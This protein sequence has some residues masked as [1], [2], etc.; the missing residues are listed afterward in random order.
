MFPIETPNR[1]CILENLGSHAWLSDR[2]ALSILSSYSEIRHEIWECLVT[3][4][5]Q[6]GQDIPSCHKYLL[7]FFPFYCKAAFPCLVPTRRG[8]A[9]KC[10]E[11]TEGKVLFQIKEKVCC[12]YFGTF[13]WFFFFC[14]LCFRLFSHVISGFCRCLVWWSKWML[15]V[16][17][18]V[19]SAL[20]A[21]QPTP[22]CRTF[23]WSEKWIWREKGATYLVWSLVWDLTLV[24]DK[25]V[26]LLR[27]WVTLSRIASK[28]C[29]FGNLDRRGKFRNCD[30]SSGVDPDSYL[31]W[32]LLR[33]LKTC[34]VLIEGE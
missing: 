1:C 13:K 17:E 6:C 10:I 34:K 30:L 18:L 27:Q 15:R 3:N 22:W 9:V 4:P 24:N 20:G 14:C 28:K 19:L 26:C 29:S 8:R 16:L 7:M 2:C 5:Q 25:C 32:C 23:S 31:F 33:T 12:D 21:A 11:N